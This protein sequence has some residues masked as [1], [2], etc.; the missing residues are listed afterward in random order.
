[1]KVLF[2]HENTMG[3]SSYLPVFAREFARRPNLGI[4]PVV[5]PVLPL[6]GRYARWGN[7]T[8]PGLR[9]WGLD[10]GFMRWRLAAS[11]QALSRVREA[12]QRETFD[13]VVVN[14]QSVGLNLAE[15]AEEMPLFVALDATFEQLLATPWVSPSP[16][17][18]ALLRP[19]LRIL[20]GGEKILYGNAT[21]ILPWSKAA[22]SSLIQDYMLKP[23]KIRCL[24]PSTDVLGAP[25]PLRRSGL[26]QALFV[27]GD[28]HR[29]G[30]P[31]LLECWRRFF[32]E[33][34]ELHVVTHTPI[35]PEPGVFVY[36]DVAH[37]SELWKRRW[38]EADF[39][40]L[41]SKLETFGIVLVEALAHG[42][43]AI[44]S[45]AGAA[46]EILDSGACGWLLKENT[47]EALRDA[48]G[49]AVNDPDERQRRGKAGWLR[50]REQYTV[51]RNTEALGEGLKMAY[52]GWAVDF[53]NRVRRELEN[54]I[55]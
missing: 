49:A 35:P 48:M 34:C 21:W 40:V 28:F 46:T 42:I 31:L 36:R 10:L 55:E 8:V 5:L 23:G 6:E 18:R 53:A 14:T 24:P 1:M 26:L 43:P 12:R 44:A 22:E 30:G 20:Q 16:L 25:K 47:L 33:R 7:W 29:K 19:T 38:A 39:L 3:H 37:G 27:G 9:R 4:E 13:A 2:V 54:E 15:I 11:R 17:A 32:R 45:T 50:A 41:P 51:A 52:L